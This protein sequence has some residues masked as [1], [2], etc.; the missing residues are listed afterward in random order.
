MGASQTAVISFKKMSE[1][2]EKN[3][4]CLLTLCR[5]L[6][7]LVVPQYNNSPSWGKKEI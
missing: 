2:S 5:R 3:L 1:A 6:V 4:A 7:L